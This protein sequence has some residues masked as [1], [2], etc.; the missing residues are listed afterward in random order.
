[1]IKFPRYPASLATVPVPAFQV[2]V[3]TYVRTYVRTYTLHRLLRTR[4]TVRYTAHY[5]RVAPHGTQ[6]T[7]F[8]AH[9]RSRCTVQYTTI[10]VSCVPGTVPRTPVHSSKLK[11]SLCT[12]RY[13]A[14]YVRG[15]LVPYGAEL[16]TYWY[17]TTFQTHL[18]ILV[19]SFKKCPTS[20]YKVALYK[21]FFN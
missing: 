17:R 16:I 7:A 10:V 19:G 2:Y 21:I 6:L 9:S 5:A 3:C 15:V 20:T 4:C 8:T 12:V 11:R 1:L 18:P 13:T 14:H